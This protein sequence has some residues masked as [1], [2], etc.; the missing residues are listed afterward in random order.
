M[1]PSQLS[2]FFVFLSSLIVAASGCNTFDPSRWNQAEVTKEITEQWKLFDVSLTKVTGGFEGSGKDASGETF[3][4]KITQDPK[5]K[6]ASGT[7]D[8]DRGTNLSF[9]VRAENK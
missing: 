2:L 7:A 3:K 6:S 9:S 5:T 1:R 4:I 8:G